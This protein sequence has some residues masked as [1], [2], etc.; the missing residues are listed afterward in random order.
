[1]GQKKGQNGLLKVNPS[2]PRAP[3]RLL[4]RPRFAGAF[5]NGGRKLSTPGGF[6][7]SL[8]RILGNKSLD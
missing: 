6:R 8:V 3:S 7:E 1:M 2:D 5:F 4:G